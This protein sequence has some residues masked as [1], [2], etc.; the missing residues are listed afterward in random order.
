MN[1][2]NEAK[3]VNVLTRVRGSASLTGQQWR[4]NSRA[5][6]RLSMLLEAYGQAGVQ[7]PDQMLSRCL[8]ILKHRGSAVLVRMAARLPACARLTET[9]Q[10]AWRVPSETNRLDAVSTIPSIG[11][12]D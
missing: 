9:H 4:A 6:E 7:L 10:G 1:S 12:A 3:R 8:H 11:L 5:A 2:R